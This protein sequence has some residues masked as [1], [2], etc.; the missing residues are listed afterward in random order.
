MLKGSARSIKGFNIY[1]AIKECDDLLEQFGGHEFAAGLSIKAENLD[2]FRNRLNR[3][4]SKRL[5]KNDF[6][7]DLPVDCD[8]YLS[9]IDMSFW[10]LLSQFEPFGPGNLR[11]V[12]V[13]KNVR[14][15]GKP[16]IVG[17]GH[18]KMRVAQNGSGPFEV[19]GFNMH[20]F[21]PIIR[22]AS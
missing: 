19:I 21:E 20:K 10:K 7:P 3:I 15:I 2:A 13:S 8:L 12:F 4:A 22:N 18:L 1:D 11:P 17:K 16:T 5:T 9:A 6:K 14:I